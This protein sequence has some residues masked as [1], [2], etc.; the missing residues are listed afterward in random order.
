MTATLMGLVFLAACVLAV[1][2]GFA[3]IV[4]GSGRVRGRGEN[5]RGRVSG[6]D[7]GYDYGSSN[8]A[9]CCFGHLFALP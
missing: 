7:R 3:R 4:T 5:D 8:P 1:G 9:A 6:H 2:V